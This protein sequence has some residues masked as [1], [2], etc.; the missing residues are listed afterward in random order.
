VASMLARPPYHVRR[1]GRDGRL[2]LGFTSTQF[3]NTVPL[4]SGASSASVLMHGAAADILVFCAGRQRVTFA[5]QDMS[6]DIQRRLSHLV[7]RVEFQTPVFT[8]FEP[9]I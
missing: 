7:R 2:A 1:R 3:G 9:A 4:T 8:P 6:K 5:W